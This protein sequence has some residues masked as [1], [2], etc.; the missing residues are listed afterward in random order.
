[1]SDAGVIHYADLGY[2]VVD[3]RWVLLRCPAEK[4]VSWS[5]LTLTFVL[6]LL[7]PGVSW[8]LGVGIALCMYQGLGTPG[9]LILCILSNCKGNQGLNTRTY[10]HR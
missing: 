5:S 1:M 4:Q 8:G 10:E 6:Q 3:I 7:I 2:H 9:S